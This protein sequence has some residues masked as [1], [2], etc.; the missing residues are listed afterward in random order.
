[1]WSRTRL[2]VTLETLFDWETG[3]GSVFRKSDGFEVLR[4]VVA[5]GDGSRSSRVVEVY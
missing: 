2:H 1:M 3:F 4:M 5:A